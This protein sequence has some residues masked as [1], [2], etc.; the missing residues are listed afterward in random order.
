V[1]AE[2]SVV[3]DNPRSHSGF[4]CFR[5]RTPMHEVT[6]IAPLRDEPG[7]I[8]YECPSCKYVRSVFVSAAGKSAL[9]SAYRP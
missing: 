6:R 1:R 3:S 7:L 8:A 5:C 9:R 2:S 4:L